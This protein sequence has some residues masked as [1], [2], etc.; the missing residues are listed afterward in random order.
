VLNR[1]LNWLGFGGKKTMADTSDPVLERLREEVGRDNAEIASDEAGYEALG[2]RHDV[3]A[4]IEREQIRPR[5]QARYA[6]RDAK[7]R[8]IAVL[9]ERQRIIN[10]LVPQ[11][12]QDLAALK[13]KA[14]AIKGSLGV[15]DQ[16]TFVDLYVHNRRVERLRLTLF[17]STHADEFAREF[18]AVEDVQRFWQQQDRER[19]RLF[20]HVLA[21]G[22]RPQNEPP[23]WLPLVM[24]L[25]ELQVVKEETTH[26]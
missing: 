15:P 19:T 8:R 10:G 20:S 14:G 26:A 9:E 18:D 1:V 4:D 2:D 24:R 22:N 12:R 25:R 17:D 21:P 5:L 13:A 16:A 7:L 6:K 3:R 11:H 23:P